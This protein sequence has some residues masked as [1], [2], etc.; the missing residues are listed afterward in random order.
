MVLLH[1]GYFQLHRVRFNG[2]DYE[3]VQATDSADVLLIDPAGQQV[4]LV[5]QPRAA[6]VRPDNHEG[7]IIEIVAGRRD[8]TGETVID[9]IVRE[10]YEE[11]GIR[12]RAN[13]VCLL[14]GGEPMAVSAGMTTE[15]CHLGVVIL[16]PAQVVV[17]PK[18][19]SAAGE[20]ENIRQLW[21]SFDDFISRPCQDVRVFA[22]QQ[23]LINYLR[24]QNEQGVT[25]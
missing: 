9:L 20:D 1:D 8:K 18:I 6:M 13:Q 16:E 24:Q 11:V 12:I 21:V 4:L 7:L 25:P 15:R 22:Y 2:R 19:F 17:S 3:V 14:N 10:T 23:Y 5:E